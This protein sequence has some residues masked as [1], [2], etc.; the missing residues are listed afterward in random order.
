MFLIE[1]NY[2]ERLQYLSTSP[3][4]EKRFSGVERMF[5]LKMHDY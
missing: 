1:N 5:R 4:Q 2:N 3:L